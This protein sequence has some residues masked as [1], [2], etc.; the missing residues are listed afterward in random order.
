M[1]TQRPE[2]AE[3][4]VRPS[5]QRYRWLLFDADGTLFD[6]ERAE[7]SALSS[8]FA[9]IGVRFDVGGL[10]TYQRINQDLWKALEKGLIRLK[11]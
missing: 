7:A 3:P 11:N 9:Q 8:A 4:A 6:Y 2:A 10:S 5:M 1:S